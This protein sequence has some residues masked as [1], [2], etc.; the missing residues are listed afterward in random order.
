MNYEEEIAAAMAEILEDAEK[1]FKQALD[2]KRLVM[3]ADLKE[4]FERVIVQNAAGIAGEISFRSYGRFKDMAKLSYLD[5]IPPVY[6]MEYFVEKTGINKFAYVPGYQ[7]KEAT[8]IKDVNRIAWA[9][10]MSM[11]RA[12][13]VKRQYRGTWYNETKMKMINNAKKRFRWITS[14]YVSWQVAQQLQREEE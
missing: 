4:S 5:H 2:E 3:S 13:N 12:V 1:M 6:A 11:K 10:A 14:E 9:I 7:N 8:S